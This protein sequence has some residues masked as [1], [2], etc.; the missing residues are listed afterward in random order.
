M[1]FN[2]KV[3]SDFPEKNIKNYKKILL[4]KNLAFF[5]VKLVKTPKNFHK[6]IKNVF[7]EKHTYK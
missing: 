7:F 3:R 5:K 2:K 4:S 1:F 6:L